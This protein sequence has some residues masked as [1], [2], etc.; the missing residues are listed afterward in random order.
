MMPGPAQMTEVCHMIVRI[1]LTAK[2]SPAYRR[3]TLRVSRTTGRPDDVAG[4]RPSTHPSFDR[5]EVAFTA[6][7]ARKGDVGKRI[8]TDFGNATI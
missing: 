1:I 2:P 6:V 3:R 4:V 8:S 5:I 7:K